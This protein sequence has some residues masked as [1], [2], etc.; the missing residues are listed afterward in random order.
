MHCKNILIYVQQ[1]AKLHSLLT[2]ICLM[3]G[4]PTEM[5]FN[6]TSTV[7]L[8][9]SIIVMTLQR[10]NTMRHDNALPVTCHSRCASHRTMHL[11]YRST[12]YT[13]NNV[14]LVKRSMIR[15]FVYLYSYIYITCVT[16]MTYD[17]RRR[18]VR[19]F[20]WITDRM[21]LIFKLGYS[22]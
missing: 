20:R 10:D 4:V 3:A 11:S 6:T 1:E 18:N 14:I 12:T 7:K 16:F 17:K 9:Q 19:V 2:Y 22:C 15:F 13:W 8:C 5:T 21:R